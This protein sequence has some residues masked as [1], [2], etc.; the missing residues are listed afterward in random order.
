MDKIQEGFPLNI[1]IMLSG[2][3]FL[4]IIITNI[5]SGRFGNETFSDLDAETKMQ[6][7]SKD[8]KKFQIGIIL[9]LIEHISIIFLAVMLFIAFNQYNIILAIAW[10]IFRI[11]ESLIQI[12][13]KKNFW[14][15]RSI[16]RQYSVSTGAEKTALIDSGRSI[17]KTKNYS[18]TI[19]QILFSI[20]TLAYSILFV[21]YGILPAIIGWS[22]IIA[23]TIYGFGNGII[24]IKPDFKVLG[25]L[26][27]L[28]ILLFEIVLGGWLIYYSII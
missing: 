18:F 5:T 21:T 9:I 24:I 26:G 14:E 17:L 7:I 4:F 23:T 2:F 3:L 27:G 19:A 25:N 6:K 1:E 20:G 11:G 16:A 10:T 28:L 12:Y 15:L 8:P 13:N 22:G